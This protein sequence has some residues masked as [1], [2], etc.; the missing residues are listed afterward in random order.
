MAIRIAGRHSSVFGRTRIAATRLVKPLDGSDVEEST[1]IRGADV[2]V[3]GC[4]SEIWKN[5][6]SIVWRCR[7]PGSKVVSSING[8][9]PFVDGACLATVLSTHPQSTV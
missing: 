1:E 2:R 4:G 6:E 9:V 3:A 7:V 8:H 5:P